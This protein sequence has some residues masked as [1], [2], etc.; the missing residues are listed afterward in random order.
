M[1]KLKET[2]EAKETKQPKEQSSKSEQYILF[3]FLL[4]KQLYI[5]DK[6]KISNSSI[7]YTIK[8]KNLSQP[9]TLNH[10]LTEIFIMNSLCARH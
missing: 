7:R 1:K 9:L 5:H 6:K 3:S 2:F 10:Y 4:Q 8:T